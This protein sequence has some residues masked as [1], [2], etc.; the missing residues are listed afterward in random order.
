MQFVGYLAA[1]TA[2]PFTIA[3]I[4]TSRFSYLDCG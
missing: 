3:S 2:C 4:A 1:I